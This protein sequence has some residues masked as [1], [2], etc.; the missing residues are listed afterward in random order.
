MSPVSKSLT[1]LAHTIA[2][3]PDAM[4]NSDDVSKTFFQMAILTPTGAPGQLGAR[5][6]VSS[7]PRGTTVS[8]IHAAA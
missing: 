5:V 3:R 1:A 6:S 2:I 4:K 7:S 8:I